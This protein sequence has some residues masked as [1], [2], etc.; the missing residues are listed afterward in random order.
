MSRLSDVAGTGEE[1]EKESVPKG[2]LPVADIPW[3]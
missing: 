3:A 1:R 2:Y